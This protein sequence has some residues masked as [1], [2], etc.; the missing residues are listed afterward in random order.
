LSPVF[1]PVRNNNG[2]FI[3]II[4]TTLEKTMK[5]KN[6]VATVMVLTT[7]LFLSGTA[8]AGKVIDEQF[9]P[10]GAKV[11]LVKA[12][13][14]NG[15]LTLAVRYI[16][17]WELT[18]PEERQK[19]EFN[20]TN[21]LNQIMMRKIPIKFKVNSVFY[22]ADGKEYHVLKDKKGNWLASPVAGEYVAGPADRDVLQKMKKKNRIPALFLTKDHPVQILWF[23]FPA[24]PE[25]VTD[26]EFQIPEVTPFDVEIKR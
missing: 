20:S 8:M 15:V 18:T 3:L 22:V 10:D 23:K 11:E 5:K 7:L 1:V 12:K 4:P 21:K 6:A 9:G 24:P 14:R 2:S 17:P 26:I 13:V 25:G 16:H 19:H